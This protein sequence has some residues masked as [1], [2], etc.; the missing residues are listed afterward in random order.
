[1]KTINRTVIAL[2]YPPKGNT[3]PIDEV[4][5]VNIY[6]LICGEELLEDCAYL[7]PKSYE[8]IFG[9]KRSESNRHKRRL[10]V[11][12]ITNSDT[13]K[14]IYRKYVF[15][16]RFT[17]MKE[18][19]IA[20]HP[21]SIRELGENGKIVGNEVKVRPGCALCYYWN[22]PLHATR[23]SAKLGIISIALAILSILLTIIMCCPCFH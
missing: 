18:A 11:V 8:Q 6:T 22:H 16:T 4:D 14:S 10:S 7:L 9:K 3:H 21:S 1:M 15:N 19:D 12:K 5:G 13:N 17:G 23:I 2:N 20:L